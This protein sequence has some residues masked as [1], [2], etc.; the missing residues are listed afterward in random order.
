MKISND[1]RALYKSIIVNLAVMAIWYA[2]EY[3]QFGELQWDRWGD[4][5]VG[6]LY[7]LILWR[8]FSKAD[9][10]HDNNPEQ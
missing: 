9:K 7:I 3:R 6:V 8:A 5:I 4:N 2:A 1:I 10:K